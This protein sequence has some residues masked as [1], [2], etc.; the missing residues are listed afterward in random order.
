MFVAVLRRRRSVRLVIL[1]G[2]LAESS[3]GR[4]CCLA[5]GP[6]NKHGKQKQSGWGA[7]KNKKLF[8][9]P[10]KVDLLTCHVVFVTVFFGWSLKLFWMFCCLGV[11]VLTDLLGR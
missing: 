3:G 11:L 1:R 6:P 7:E 9:C 10:R 4:F 8:G 5:F 2:Y